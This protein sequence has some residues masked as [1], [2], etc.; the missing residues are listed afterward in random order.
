MAWLVLGPEVYTCSCGMLMCS[1]CKKAHEAGM[2]HLC[3]DRPDKG[4]GDVLA[5]GRKEGWV[6]CPGCTVTD[7]QSRQN[8][9]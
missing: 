2:K 1:M 5:L 7:N 8:P 3:G 4:I 9:I 6:R